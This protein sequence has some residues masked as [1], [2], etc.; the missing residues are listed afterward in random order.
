LTHCCIAITMS[1]FYQTNSASGSSPT[2]EQNA[3]L[4]T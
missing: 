4:E 3:A 1:L 2:A